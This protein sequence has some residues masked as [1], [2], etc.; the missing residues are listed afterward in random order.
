MYTHT[1][2]HSKTSKK[3]VTRNTKH[4]TGKHPREKLEHKPGSTRPRR[5]KTRRAWP[6]AWPLGSSGSPPEAPRTAPPFAPAACCKGW[7]PCVWEDTPPPRVHGKNEK[8]QPPSKQTHAVAN[9]SSG[10]KEYMA[11]R[12]DAKDD[13]SRECLRQFQMA[14]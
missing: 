13:T 11:W 5:R 9:K 3:D 1:Y 14:N 7:W 8:R 10:F 2:I 4:F 12:D 6:Q